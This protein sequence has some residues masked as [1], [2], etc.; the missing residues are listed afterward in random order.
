[1]WLRLAMKRVATTGDEACDYD[2]HIMTNHCFTNL[3]FQ[4]F[5]RLLSQPFAGLFGVRDI[6]I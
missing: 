1:V 4:Y 3:N 6:N 2:S 5:L